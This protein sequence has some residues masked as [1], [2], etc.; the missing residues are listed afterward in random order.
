[1]TDTRLPYFTPAC[2]PRFLLEGMGGFS[3]MFLPERYSRSSSW[4]NS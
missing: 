2:R 1:M 3:S 4:R